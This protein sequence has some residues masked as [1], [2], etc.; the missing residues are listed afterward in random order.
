MFSGSSLQKQKFQEK[1][2]QYWF[3]IGI[4]LSSETEGKNLLRYWCLGA[5]FM[6]FETSKGSFY[7]WGGQ[8]ARRWMC[9][10]DAGGDGGG[11]EGGA[12]GEG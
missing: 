7:V 8:W 10:V 6:A 4:C 3:F 12:R 9:G 2:H 1:N 5:S 11:E